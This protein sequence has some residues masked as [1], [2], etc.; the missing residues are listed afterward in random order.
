MF[1]ERFQGLSAGIAAAVCYGMNP[2]GAK[3]LYAE[4]LS[5]DSVLFYRYALAALLL[6]AWVAARGEGFAVSRRE[7]GVAAVLGA[8]FAVSSLTFFASFRVMDSGL[9][10]TLLFVYPAM[11]AGIMAL[12][13]GERLT[14]AMGGALALALAGI[15]LLCRGGEGGVGATGVALVMASA[16]TY[17]LYIV[18]V[19]RARLTLSAAKLTFYVLLF[20]LPL[21]L[22]HEWFLGQA[23]PQPLT[24]PTMILWALMLAIVPTV[25]S[26]SLMAVAARRVGSTPTAVTGALEPLTALAIGVT[27]F[28][29]TFSPRLAL[30]VALIVGA[31][32]LLT[33]ATARRPAA[34]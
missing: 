17:A 13:F 5:A 29:E 4:G 7:M 19:N 8:L 34:A 11:V 28:G 32:T 15:G 16:L 10:C 22:A 2:L 24:S 20:G 18:V 26:L 12:C 9:A 33:L 6:G 14:W 27:V 31:V 3:A 21:L 1:G 30:G 25:L 23:A